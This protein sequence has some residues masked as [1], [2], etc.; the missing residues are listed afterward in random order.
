MYIVVIIINIYNIMSHPVEKPGRYNN[1]INWH[2]VIIVSVV[3][4]FI[5][6]A[7]GTTVVVVFITNANSNT[8]KRII[9][10]SPFYEADQTIEQTKTF[11][12]TVST[13][14][15]APTDDDDDELECCQAFTYESLYAAM[16]VYLTIGADENA[17][18]LCDNT[19]SSA[20]ISTNCLDYPLPSLQNWE[21]SVLVNSI[22]FQPPLQICDDMPIIEQPLIPVINL[23]IWMAPAPYEV[24]FYSA[25]DM[26][27]YPVT[28]SMCCQYFKR[29]DFFT[30]VAAGYQNICGTSGHTCSPASNPARAPDG[31]TDACWRSKLS[32]QR[33]D[34]SKIVNPFVQFTAQSFFGTC[35]GSIGN[36]L[37]NTTNGYPIY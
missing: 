1:W 13:L 27:P 30:L 4:V 34:V 33:Y 22:V 19:C 18:I 17:R 10:S 23:G 16:Q 8:T 9:T 35:D 3:T 7:V 25:S 21:R 24:I 36:Y 11:V 29:L 6:I 2:T 15:W 28:I 26:T 20:D 5:L 32:L 31:T 12:I 14:K 37:Y